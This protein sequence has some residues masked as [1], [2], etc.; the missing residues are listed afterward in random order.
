M[1]GMKMRMEERGK[2]QRERSREKEEERKR[3][4]RV[5]H[6]KRDCGGFWS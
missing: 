6:R 4:C 2:K 3:F 5:P 1:R